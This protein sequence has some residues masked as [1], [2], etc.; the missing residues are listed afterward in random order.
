MHVTIHELLVF[1][2]QVL[3]D[4]KLASDVIAGTIG[5]TLGI[6]TLE[7]GI[8]GGIL[9]GLAVACLHNRFYRIELPVVFSFFGGVRFVPII[10]TLAAIV[11]G[12]I[13]F[14]VWPPI[15]RL[16]LASGALDE[17]LLA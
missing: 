10:C 14:Y 7:M 15:Q 9:V 1:S 2:G 12:V 16:I 5:T 11:L 8:F 6:Q 3:P 13:C 4:G 17:Y